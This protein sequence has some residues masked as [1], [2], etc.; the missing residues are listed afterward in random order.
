MSLVKELYEPYVLSARARISTDP[1]LRRL[2]DPA[3]SP[4]VLE[5]F[6][7]QFH[8]L[9]VYMTEPL[10]GWNRRAGHRS[11]L[12]S[13][14]ALGKGLLAH[15]KQ[16][17]GLPVTMTEDVDTLVRRW[18]T[19]YRPPL[20]T[21]RLLSQYPTDAMRAWRRL[22]EETLTGELPPAQIAIESELLHLMQTLAPHLLANVAR[23]LGRE[24][25]EGL[26][27]LQEQ[28][29]PDAPRAVNQARLL[30]ELVRTVPESARTLAELGGEAIEL[31]LRFIEDCLESAE[32][33]LWTPTLTSLLGQ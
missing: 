33:A 16:A 19:R 2:V 17:S 7:I 26:G 4:E 8:A 6:F 11:L 23:V 30:E 22:V 10:E 1:V 20:H 13:M 14:D 15:S 9:G 25:L 3:V 29:Q 12:L 24:A 27:A 21:E 32:S 31:Y 28:A 5:R 18:N